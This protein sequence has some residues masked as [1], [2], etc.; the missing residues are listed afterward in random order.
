MFAVDTNV[1]VHA[2]DRSCPEHAACAALVAR[3]RSQVDPWYVSWNVV[4]EFVRVVTHPR[5]FRKPWTAGAA[6]SFVEAVFASP[7][8]IILE[9]TQR[10]AAIVAQTLAEMP[11]LSG[12]LVHDAH[13]AILMREH[14]LRRIYTRD[15][16]FHRFTFVEVIDPLATTR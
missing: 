13:T 8:L 11:T 15:A 1:L 5:V 6:W 3:W 4:Y 9:H 12:N 2:A 16:G 7:S 10:H 14:G